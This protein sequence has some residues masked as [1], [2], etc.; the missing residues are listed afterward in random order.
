MP[1]LLLLGLLALSS[2]DPDAF[3]KPLDSATGPEAALVWIQG[4]LIPSHTYTPL[5]KEMQ[6]A[7]A[8]KLW[9]GQPSF[10][11]DTPEPALLPHRIDTT[12][13]MMRAAG[14][15]TTTIFF[16]A[17][18]LG[19]VFLQQYC[20]DKSNGCA[21][22]ILTGGP[23]ART[24]YYPSFRH[25][26]QPHLRGSSL[27]LLWPPINTRPHLGARSQ[28]RG[29]DADDGGIDGRAVPRDPCD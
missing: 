20:A 15:N 19:T 21:G 4:A 23:I 1:R 27:R 14:M 8:L 9:I 17:H 16:G 12:L 11:A 25:A 18:S 7:S 13:K 24:N 29:A 2:A 5:L 28:L 6:A 10:T 26:P 22:Q 3:L